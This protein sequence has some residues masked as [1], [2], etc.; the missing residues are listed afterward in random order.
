MCQHT[1]DDDDVSPPPLTQKPFSFG[2]LL[3]VARTTSIP[4]IP[5]AHRTTRWIIIIYRL[6]CV[7]VLLCS[8]RVF[9]YDYNNTY[10]RPVGCHTGGDVK[11]G[12]ILSF[13][14]F[15]DFIKTLD[16]AAGRSCYT[17]NCL[18]LSRPIER[19]ARDGGGEYTRRSNRCKLS[20][21]VGSG[22]GRTQD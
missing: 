1:L 3:G 13:F 4:G 5:L 22:V 14:F 18:L 15:F 12:K 17:C 2:S 6:A 11:N 16:G 21:P 20:G 7:C 9:L 10:H 8:F 19:C